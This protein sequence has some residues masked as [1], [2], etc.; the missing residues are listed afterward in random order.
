MSR[1]SPFQR[2]MLTRLRHSLSPT[3]K[4][5]P[6]HVNHDPQ[7]CALLSINRSLS[8]GID[9]FTN[10]SPEQNIKFLHL[11]LQST[12]HGCTE[13]CAA[14]TSTKTRGPC[15]R[16]EPFGSVRTTGVSVSLPN[17][18]YHLTPCPFHALSLY[19]FTGTPTFSASNP[20]LHRMN[21]IRLRTQCRQ[22]HTE[23]RTTF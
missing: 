11:S 7:F 23:N 21:T 8:H 15:I 13:S 4:F 16:F 14:T 19:R 10:R 1:W 17:T 20:H 3:A 22:P 9:Q 2:T 6:R 18:N 12:Y 5:H